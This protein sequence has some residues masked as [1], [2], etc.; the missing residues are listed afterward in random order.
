MV[1]VEALAAGLQA[2]EREIVE[3]R[4]WAERLVNQIS[5]LVWCPHV[6]PGGGVRLL[7]SL[8]P[9]LAEQPEASYV[10]VAVP[11]GSL[12]SSDS[13][14]LAAAG[15]TVT[16][17]HGESRGGE[18]R[19]RI[20]EIDG[21]PYRIEGTP[22]WS[23]EAIGRLARACDVVYA[24]WPHGTSCPTV[25]QSLVCT[26]QDTTLI[27][28]PEI[29][30]GWGTA[31][32]AANLEGWMRRCEATVVSSEATKANLIRLLGDIGESVHVVHHAIRPVPQADS[33]HS[34]DISDLLAGLPARY[35]VCP[36]NIT[37]HKNLD[38]LVI[39]WSRFDDRLAWPLV[40]CGHSTGD[41]AGVDPAEAENWRRT[42]IAGLVRRSGVRIGSDL[43]PLGYVPDAA[44]TPLISGAAGLVMPSLTEGGGSFPVE[45]A[46]SLGVP[47]LC[48]DIPVMR[49][50]LAQR[51]ATVGWFNPTEPSSIL[52]AVEEFVRDYDARLASARAGM[53][54]RRPTWSDVASGY[55]KVFSAA[56]AARAGQ[57]ANLVSPA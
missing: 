5:V 14:R 19:A 9:G 7:L 10:A 1:S 29:L 32:E 37:S 36:T 3:L 35:I 11:A 56:V 23:Q 4:A 28:F 22:E 42:Q 26:I 24:P 2:L 49:E 21:V 30:G 46:L 54:D 52:S 17:L 12:S 57:R 44:I 8:L 47:V 51:T 31:Q 18:V 50:H 16:E 20:H 53:A 15:V 27:D 40:V 38:N 13:D 6:N 43:I 45:E 41:L 34:S 48:S 39:A 55:T 25:D 33:E